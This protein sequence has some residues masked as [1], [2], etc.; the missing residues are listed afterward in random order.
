M[1]SFALQCNICEYSDSYIFCTNILLMLSLA[2]LPS[3]LATAQQQQRQKLAN[4]IL[5]EFLTCGSF[6]VIR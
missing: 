1:F 4:G 3:P 2:D 6:I 5:L